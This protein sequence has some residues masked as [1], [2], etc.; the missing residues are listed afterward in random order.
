M[1]HDAV[2]AVVGGI[3]ESSIV[4]AERS[5]G[6]PGDLQVG[7]PETS[8][9]DSPPRSAAPQGPLFPGAVPDKA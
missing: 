8:Y 9:P 2:H 5:G 7:G 1:A 4:L 3:Q 6:A